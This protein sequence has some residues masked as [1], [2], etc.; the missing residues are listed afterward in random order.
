MKWAPIGDTKTKGWVKRCGLSVKGQAILPSGEKVGRATAGVRNR[1]VSVRLSPDGKAKTGLRTTS[2]G[3][4]PFVD[5]VRS[6]ALAVPVP[7]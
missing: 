6:F 5:V 4:W 7:L 1:G 3:R 2:I